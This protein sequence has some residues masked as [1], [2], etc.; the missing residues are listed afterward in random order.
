MGLGTNAV[1]LL[2]AEMVSD[3]PDSFAGPALMPPS[4]TVCS[5]ASSRIATGLAIAFSVGASLTALTV[6]LTV[7]VLLAAETSLALYVNESV[8]LKFGAGTYVNDPLLLSVTAPFDGLL[9]TL[10]V[11]A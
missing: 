5:P 6:M 9:T 3:W 1:L 2:V 7:A 4:A 11:S 10:L 8:P